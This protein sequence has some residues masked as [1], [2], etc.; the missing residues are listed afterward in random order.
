MT[1]K[2]TPVHG[3]QR[4]IFHITDGVR[5]LLYDDGGE[6]VGLAHITATQ[7]WVTGKVVASDKHAHL[8]LKRIEW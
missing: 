3:V 7:Q 1:S 4:D 5:A 6:V 2:Q 8:P